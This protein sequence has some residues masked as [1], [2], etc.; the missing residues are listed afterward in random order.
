MTS[1]TIRHHTAL[2]HHQQHRAVGALVGAAVG[3]AL[4]APFE[5]G[6][7]GQYSKQFSQPVV[8]G[9][10]EMCGGGGFAWRPGEFTDD[11]QMALALAESLITHGG[12]DHADLWVRWRAW[13]TNA[14]DIGVITRT[15]LRH[16]EW[17]GAAQAAH[18]ALGR[19]A[20][21]GS[22]MR[23]V[24]LALAY[25]TADPR[26]AT[27]ITMRA[28]LEQSALTHFDPAAGWGSAVWAEL[29]RR[30]IIGADPLAEVGAVMARV[31]DE[32]RATFAPLLEPDWEP[33]DASNPSNGSVWGCLAQ[34]L[35]A[36]RH[37]A[38]FHD[39]LVA[40]ID[41]G[42]DTDTVASVTGALAGA[43]CGIQAIPSRWTTYVH[44]SVT[45]P[46]GTA[47]Y[48]NAQ[49][50]DVAR[51]LIGGSMPDDAPAESPAG[52]QEILDGVWAADL[53]AAAAQVHGPN[54]WA[55]L[56]LCRTGGSFADV[57]DR[58]EVYLVDKAGD[59]NPALDEAVR[60]AVD[61]IDA[62]RVEGRQVLVHC[63]GGR[64]RTG[65]VLKAWAM[66]HHDWTE[67]EAHE[68]LG[69]VWHRYDPWNTTFREFLRDQWPA[70]TGD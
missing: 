11:T 14:A 13:A 53:S 40:A 43:R 58:R 41:L 4:G 45:T 51:R 59:A 62:W 42:A 31:P 8:G 16:A 23:V 21:N 70:A 65:L 20:G 2:T 28:A 7:A 60:D 1:L 27:A 57:V 39:A 46:T 3:D 49:L 17:S 15:S 35:W 63:H 44:G 30:T 26:M 24:P 5:F 55:V 48:D 9:T 61:T 10:G 52:P 22:L 34:A 33:E 38:T 66:R 37:H 29:V 56:S 68:W 6:P 32:V 47:R 69:R 36:V 67:A 64:S 19:S 54:G 18:E 25:A 50:Q 12:I